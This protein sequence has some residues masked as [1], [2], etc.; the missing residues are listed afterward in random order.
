MT[1]LDV[2][3]LGPLA[4]RVDGVPVPTGGP[5]QRVVL[6]MLLL[7][8]N[9]S[10]SIDELTE[11]VWAGGTPKNP[12]AVLQV[13]I[14]NLRRLLSGNRNGSAS[15]RIETTPGGYRIIVRTDEFDYLLFGRQIGE[16]TATLNIGDLREAARRL[17][18]ALDLWHGVAFADLSAIAAA[19]PELAALTERRLTAIEDLL[20]L[21][22]AMEPGH[23]VVPEAARL[24]EEHPFRERLRV[25]LV[26]ALYRAQRQGDALAACRRTRRFLADE[27]GVEPGLVF[28]N[29][30]KAVLRQ[31][32]E[33]G[34]TRP[35]RAPAPA[36]ASSLPA[37]PSSF[38]GR[39]EDLAELTA[40]LTGGRVRSIT[41][42]GTG[43]VGKTRL[44]LAAAAAVE[45]SFPD[46]AAW[47]P[48]DTVAAAG[49]VTGAIAEVL[50]IRAAPQRAL[51]DLVREY[52]RP[53]RMLLVL[54]NFE[55]VADAWQVIVD[56]LQTAARLTVLATSRTPLQ[57]AGE[58][59]FEVLPLDL[60]DRD[61]PLATAFDCSSVQLFL[62]RARLA[63]RR[64]RID[65]ET[66]GAVIDVCRRLDGLPLA[67]ELA[68]ALV[69]VLE[70]GS[71][72]R[73]L[74][75]VLDTLVGG[76]RDAAP[77][78]R[79][80]RD[81][82]EWS[83][84]LLTPPEQ[85]VFDS[86][87]AFAAAPDIDAVRAVSGGS[88]EVPDAMATLVRHGLVQAAE[89]DLGGRF[90]MLQTV[91]AFATEALVKGGGE[92]TTRRRHAEHYL[93][94]AQDL[95]AR[96][97][98]AGQVAAFR[99]LHLERAEL[100]A[101]LDWAA[102]HD[103]DLDL[104]L[105]LV[106]AQWEY[107]AITGDVAVPR[108]RAEDT[109]SRPWTGDPG[110][111]AEAASAAGTLC[112]LLG[113]LDSAVRYHGEALE[114]FRDSG[115]PPG[116]AW[117]TMCLAVQEANAGR[118]DAAEVTARTALELARTAGAPHVLAG[119]HV[120]L[121]VLAIYRGDG[122]AAERHQLDALAISEDSGDHRAAAMALINLSDIAEGRGEW[123]QAAGFVRRA[124]RNSRRVG[125]NVQALFGIE[126]MGELRLRL[127]APVAAA[128]LLGAAHRHR[129]SMAQPLD[130]HE[131]TA[132]DDI[133]DEIRSA[134]GLVA[135]AVAWAEG[136]ELTLDAAIDMAIAG[137][138]G[139]GS[140][141]R[142]GDAPAQRA[143]LDG[144][145]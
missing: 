32:P 82:I 77:R 70:P 23:A 89:R 143:A 19:T 24:V 103:G 80:L 108:R 74:R 47:V 51:E 54:D 3:C 69:S 126:A 9:A 73:A 41:L 90:S 42:T 104:A 98:D 60:P 139:D 16:A 35:D 116:V 144:V 64:F 75:D 101:A 40:L 25:V 37:A 52:L 46:G 130:P 93:R 127:G 44:A 56:L 12:R 29:A 122:R 85:V 2:R 4:V 131:R 102:G 96:L 66:C 68:A 53:R 34:R 79:S 15:E 14:A 61:A 78:H 81:T 109:L 133:L 114:L 33:F 50:G 39:A 21:R 28:Q 113:D 6:S 123:L 84:H 95:R 27:L 43:G 72:S 45:P 111:R 138:T 88:P 118:F 117:S 125:D 36:A 120:T 18:S 38:V 129:T 145:L 30:E 105:R 55:H 7:R 58:Q 13:Y 83:Y 17:R 92:R 141:R 132:L 94:L 142:S 49:R 134:A 31:D 86:M 106:G 10:V 124:L 48:L 67:I 110:I 5:K 8:A 107:W 76:P 115:N 112:W 137:S 59:R 1:L 91:K 62:A 63:D 26:T 22:L 65:E 119:C 136:L 128:R 140:A 57:I 87:A 135:F 71:L 100:D 99:R 20:E 97:H 11:A 121:G